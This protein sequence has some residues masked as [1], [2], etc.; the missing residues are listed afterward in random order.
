[1]TEQ[2]VDPKILDEL[3][4]DAKEPAAFEAMF[5]SLKKSLVERALGA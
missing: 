3:L 1:M 4:K 5:R 2:N